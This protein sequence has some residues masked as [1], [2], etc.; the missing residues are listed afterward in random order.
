MQYPQSRSTGRFPRIPGRQGPD[1]PAE[2]LVPA[3]G[4]DALDAGTL[5]AGTLDADTLDADTLDEGALDEGTATPGR[6]EPGD[7][8]RDTRLA[9]ERTATAAAELA[10]FLDLLSRAARPGPAVDFASQR[11]LYEPR[12]YTGPDPA[13]PPRW[14]DFAPPEPPDGSEDNPDGSDAGPGRRLL[15]PA[16]QRERAQA[17]LRHQRALREWR[18]QQE[19]LGDG[20]AAPQDRVHR[21]RIEHERAELARA[22]AVEEYNATLDECHRAYRAGEPAAV[23]SLLERAL[24]A[25]GHATPDLPTACR[26]AYRPLT[27]TAVLDLELPSPQIVPSVAGYRPAPEGGGL[28]PVPRPDSERATHYLQLAARLTLRA[29]HAVAAADSDEVLSGVVLNGYVRGPGTPPG[30]SCLL[31][32]D[33]DRDDL[34]RTRL[35]PAGP[36][37]AAP[38]L[39]DALAVLR[40]LPST[41]TPDPYGPVA[42]PPH[43]TA[44]AAVPAAADLSPA[45]F[46]RLVRELLARMGLD[47]WTP[48]L[49]GRDGLVAVADGTDGTALPGRWVVWAARRPGSVDAD[50]VRTLD[51]AVTEESADGGLWLTTTHFTPEAA[52]L[53]A[54]EDGLLL[55]DGERLRLLLRTHLGEELAG[56]G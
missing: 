2:G 12:P 46:G 53:A 6:E 16:Y 34:A 38:D 3:Q 32:V 36:A 4:N 14:E 40:A 27:R 33:A 43:A 50:A 15:D 13:G 17:R 8:D 44:G 48:R 41:V 37:P 42:V 9:R 10:R 55:I 39:E 24:A 11:R 7:R 45:E 31:T 49:Q 23:E 26:A 20:G 56:E 30:G 47:G 19:L 18:E 22:R 1:D 5:D 54:A 51:E 28:E 29:L 25:A 52:E 35:L 21:D